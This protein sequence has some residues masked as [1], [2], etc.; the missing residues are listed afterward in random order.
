M[1]MTKLPFASVVVEYFL[2]V[3]VLVAVMLTPG[4]GTEPDLTC[5]RMVPP[6]TSAEGVGAGGEVGCARAGD[7]AAGAVCD[8]P[9]LV[10]VV[11]GA[12]WA[13]KCKF[14]VNGNSIASQKALWRVRDTQYPQQQ[15]GWEKRGF[16]LVLR[17]WRS[18][19]G[20]AHSFPRTAFSFGPRFENAECRSY[21]GSA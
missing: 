4:S 2:P 8:E 1:V 18:G 10:V 11:S 16:F 15:N 17:Y 20:R 19:S 6:L 9:V 21:E 5:P 12:V 7:G 13:I 3:R 14:P